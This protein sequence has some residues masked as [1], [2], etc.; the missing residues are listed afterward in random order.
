MDFIE[1]V[2]KDTHNDV[3]TKRLEIDYP[4]IITEDLNDHVMRDE[5][6]YGVEE[7]F[8]DDEEDP[9]SNPKEPVV[10]NENLKTEE[11]P[12]E[13]DDIYLDSSSQIVK[14]E[15]EHPPIKMGY[16]ESVKSEHA[17]NVKSEV[18]LYPQDYQ[19][20][21][22]TYHQ[23]NYEQ[24]MQTDPESGDV[25]HEFLDSNYEPME[26]GEYDEEMEF[27]NQMAAEAI[28]RGHTGEQNGYE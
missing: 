10:I 16:P 4:Y 27:E 2:V 5:T 23:S 22:S 3:H 7:T 15:S 8:F 18:T 13:Q 19:Y 14:T 24:P 11:P 26:E 28:E 17:E 6:A 20:G 12:S 21:P 9:S 1:R 25:L